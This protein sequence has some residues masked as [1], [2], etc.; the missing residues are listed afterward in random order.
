MAK[1]DYFFINKE[2]IKELAKEIGER[3]I[4][5][6]NVENIDYSFDIA[7]ETGRLKTKQP[8][9]SFYF[10]TNEGSVLN[11]FKKALFDE[12]LEHVK[13]D[14][15]EEK[16]LMGKVRNLLKQVFGEIIYNYVTDIR[17]TLRKVIL[18]GSKED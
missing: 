11:S 17:D 7:K 4:N 5:D 15:P 8:N 18:P 14:T 10:D 9:T 6:A 3:F 12:D 2:V 1:I 16:E 13:Q